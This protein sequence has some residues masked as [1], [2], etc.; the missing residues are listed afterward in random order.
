MRGAVE[1]RVAELG[2]DERAVDAEAPAEEG[3]AD[4]GPGSGEVV[5]AGVGVGAEAVVAGEADEVDV[6]PEGDLAVVVPVGGVEE[7][8]G[9]DGADVGDEGAPAVGAVFE[10]GELAADAVERGAFGG[11][12]AGVVQDEAVVARPPARLVGGAEGAAPLAEARFSTQRMGKTITVRPRA[13]A[14]RM[15]RRTSSSAG[16]SVGCGASSLAVTSGCAHC[17]TTESAPAP[18]SAARSTI[19]S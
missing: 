8:A 10:R 3:L 1:A 2:E 9:V 16:V 18:A 15:M 11:G 6:L 19:A 13:R 12:E 14:R 17:T 5:D 7:P 4:G